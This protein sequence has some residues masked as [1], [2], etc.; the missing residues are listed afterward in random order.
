MGFKTFV[1]NTWDYGKHAATKLNGKL[2]QWGS[3]IDDKWVN[4]WQPATEKFIGT[5]VMNKIANTVGDYIDNSVGGIGKTLSTVTKMVS[6]LIPDEYGGATIK[7]WAKETGQYLSEAG[8]KARGYISPSLATTQSKPQ[9]RPQVTS[10]N[11]P[12]NNPPPQNKPPNNPPPQKPIIVFNKAKE[13]E[14]E[15]FVLPQKK[16]A[17][18]INP[19]RKTN[20]IIFNKKDQPLPSPSSILQPQ[21]PFQIKPPTLRTVQAVRTILR[22][23]RN[24]HIGRQLA[25]EWDGSHPF[26]TPSVFGGNRG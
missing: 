15:E 22:A 16:Q 2:G 13:E 14:E 3:F 26:G 17:P 18:P 24:G 4:D 23:K 6:P 10:Q 20:E 1:K 7:N 8:K 19:Y 5:E 21:S 12:P 9:N 25:I 11:K